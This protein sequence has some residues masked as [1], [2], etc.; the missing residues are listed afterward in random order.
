MGE[1]VSMIRLVLFDIDGTLILTGGAGM[2]AF[3]EAF[4]EAFDLPNA[5]ESMEFA[6]RTDRGLAY[7]V[8]RANQIEP[9][10]ANF[11]RFTE[12]YTQQLAKHLPAD[13][14]QPLPGV[15]EL[16]DAI[17]ARATPPM[18]GLLT[19]NLP[20]GA[21]LKLTH[22]HLWHRF[23]FGAFG[24]TTEDRNEIA[25]SAFENAQGQF[26]N[27]SPSEILIIGDTPADIHCAQSIG[28][29]VLAVA[30]GSYTEAQL[31]EHHPTFLAP[32]LTNLSLSLFNA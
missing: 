27:L 15:V 21:E 5:T 18:L 23:E 19:G 7:E 17:E 20:L 2:K 30:T 12:V 13:N 31:A 3:T 6:G 11:E 32:D 24:D 8:F 22:Y 9:T 14:T 26:P 10:Q 1:S 25:Q 28:A 4:A 29:R 16:L